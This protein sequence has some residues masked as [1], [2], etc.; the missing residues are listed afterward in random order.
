MTRGIYYAPDLV[1]QAALRTQILYPISLQNR[2]IPFSNVFCKKAN[3]R[4]QK[5]KK[6]NVHNGLD[7]ILPKEITAEVHSCISNQPNNPAHRDVGSI[8]VHVITDHHQQIISRSSK[9]KQAGTVGP[10]F[11]LIK[12]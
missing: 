4:H 6:R 11:Y 8:T 7:S 12:E 9:P 3:T 1:T 5:K 2:E 10:P